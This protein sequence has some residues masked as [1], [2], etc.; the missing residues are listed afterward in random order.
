[1]TV[2]GVRDAVAAGDFGQ[3][4][5][6]TA[7]TVAR[8]AVRTRRSPSGGGFWTD[9]EIDEL[10]HETVVRARPDKLVLAAEEAANDREFMWGWLKL[11]LRT[12][13]NIRARGT[14]AGRVLRAMDDALREEPDRFSLSNGYWR[15]RSDGPERASRIGRETLIR[16]AWTVQTDTI[17]VS[18]HATKTPPMAFRRDIRAVS[19]KLLELS[20]PLA[21]A[22]LAEVLAHR[23]NVSFEAR[24]HYLDLDEGSRLL[25]GE[26]PAVGA[27]DATEDRMLAR[28]MLEQLTKDEREILQLVLD[29]ASLRD[30]ASAL[31]CSKYR[32]GI[33]RS[34]LV[35]K[36]R[37]LVKRSS[38]DA[39]G[40]VECLIEMVGQHTELRHSNE[41]DGAENGD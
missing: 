35:C 31:G 38:G 14:P 40:A 19:A 18:K 25:P 34:R 2:D 20:G 12:S 41:R 3:Q 24:F 36:M 29:N 7:R 9:N 10:I 28:W 5:V 32:A 1:M 30:L 37:R 23:F 39:Q 4:F 16:A 33:I 11:A 27:L 8:A 17:R 13:L 21:K 6:D 22:D 26:D 15:L